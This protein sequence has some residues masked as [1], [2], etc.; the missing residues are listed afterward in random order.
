VH[1]LPD[2]TKARVTIH[3]SLLLRLQDEADKLM[4]YAR[5]VADL[6]AAAALAGPA[7]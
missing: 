5:F 4:Q 1:V 6:R 7:A 3:P 2:G